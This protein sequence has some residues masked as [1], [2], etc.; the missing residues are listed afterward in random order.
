M[1]DNK[2]CFLVELLVK[3]VIEPFHSRGQHPCKCI[4]EKRTFLHKEMIRTIQDWFVTP[5]WPSFHCFRHQYD[6]S[7]VM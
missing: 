1:K 4:L 7:D 3:V 5:T 6:G 2:L